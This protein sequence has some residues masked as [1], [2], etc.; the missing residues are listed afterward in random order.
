MEE[1]IRINKFLS[2]AGVCS[3]READREIQNGAVTIDGVRARIGSRVFTGQRVLFLG[4]EVEKEPERILLAVHKPI[5]IVCT[6]AKREKDNIVDFIHY[7]KRIYPVGRLDKS[8]SGLILMTN[9]GDIVNKMMRAGNMHEKE[10][11]VTVNKP[12]TDFFIRGMAGGV[13][14][15]ELQVMTR[16]CLVEP[17]GKREFRIVLTQ[18]Y[19][20]QIRRMCEYFD[21]R[22]EK[23]KRVRIMNIELGD[24]KE[25]SYRNVTDEEWR[26]LKRM[27]QGS[28]NTP[29]VPYAGKL[30]RRR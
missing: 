27:L 22:V 6:A 30:E 14:L 3:R 21:Y 11:I 19:N 25:G 26:E 17:L 16:K 18:G 1:G 12:L 28:V 13:P 20:R 29:V 4:K 24:L 15:S 9:N 5:G 23:L 2:E 10:Y 7:P 8:S